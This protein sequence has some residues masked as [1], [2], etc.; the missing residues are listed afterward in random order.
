MARGG[1]RWD[2]IFIYIYITPMGGWGGSLTRSLFL[3][4]NPFSKKRV[5]ENNFFFT[6]IQPIYSCSTSHTNNH[7]VIDD[8]TTH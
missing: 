2:F 7:D 3:H 6:N 5:G 1:A 8:V 4:L